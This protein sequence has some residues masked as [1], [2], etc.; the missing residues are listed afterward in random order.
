MKRVFI[1][2]LLGLLALLRE[3]SAEQKYI[4]HVTQAGDG[5]Y[6]IAKRYGTSTDEL[7]KLNNIKD[8]NKLY[9][10]M[11]LKVPVRLSQ[12]LSNAGSEHPLKTASNTAEQNK[13]APAAAVST[14]QN[15]TVIPDQG[16]SKPADSEPKNTEAHSPASKPTQQPAGAS[17]QEAASGKQQSIEHQ[18][19]ERRPFLPD[20]TSFDASRKPQSTPLL[21]LDLLWKLALVLVLV[22]VSAKAVKLLSSRSWKGHGHG[23]MVVLDSLS[24]GPNRGVYLIK[25]FGRVLLLGVTPERIDLLIELPPDSVPEELGKAKQF[26]SLLNRMLGGETE[27]ATKLGDLLDKTTQHFRKR[28]QDAQEGAQSWQ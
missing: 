2:L 25:A 15:A 14:A 1:C 24:L 17:H 3:A 6:S 4:I 8:P 19:K 16:A 11:R 18:Q 23:Q 21:I 5:L 20:Y 27:S 10:G 26:G 13:P 22:V 28:A 7:I 9:R 12:D